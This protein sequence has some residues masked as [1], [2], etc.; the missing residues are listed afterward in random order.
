MAIGR[1]LLPYQLLRLSSTYRYDCFLKLTHQNK[2]LILVAEFKLH[3]ESILKDLED[4]KAR[5]GQLNLLICWD[6]D[7]AKLRREGFVVEP[8]EPTKKELPGATHRLA[9]P[10]SVGIKDQPI[11]VIALSKLINCT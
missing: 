10:I 1:G 2:P 7:E 8:L 6:L 4:S 3:G 5:Y 11:A 9:F